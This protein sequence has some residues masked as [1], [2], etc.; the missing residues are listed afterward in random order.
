M[1]KENL[2]ISAA[3]VG[4]LKITLGEQDSSA[5]KDVIAKAAL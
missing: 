5:N 3:L 1:L 4:Y 2:K